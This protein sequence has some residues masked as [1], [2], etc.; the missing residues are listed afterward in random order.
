MVDNSI[1]ALIGDGDDQGYRLTLGPAKRRRPVQEDL[2]HVGRSLYRARSDTK[3][4]NNVWNEADLF[5]KGFV[6]LLDLSP[7]L[8]V[9]Y[10]LNPCHGYPSV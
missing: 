8:I 1:V 6:K 3:E 9:I 5:F 7:G 2:E 4:L 10:C